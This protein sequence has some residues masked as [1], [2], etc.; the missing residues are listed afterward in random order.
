ML[1]EAEWAQLEPALLAATQE[2]KDRRERGLSLPEAVATP[3]GRPALL[4]HERLTGEMATSVEPLWHHRNSLHGPP[5]V[6]CG[7]PLRTPRARV[8]AGCGVARA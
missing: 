7:K 4:L 2:I 5:C 6:S 1:T 3:Y 8:C